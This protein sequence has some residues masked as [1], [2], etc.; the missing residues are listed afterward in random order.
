MTEMPVPTRTRRFRKFCI[1]ALPNSPTLLCF[2]AR[3]RKCGEC[4][5]GLAAAPKHRACTFSLRSKA[6][7]RKGIYEGGSGGVC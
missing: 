7:F 1:D 5:A 2:H 6:N 3:Y 4:E